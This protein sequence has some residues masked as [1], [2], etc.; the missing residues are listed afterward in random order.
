V[1]DLGGLA[2]HARALKRTLLLTPW[3]AL[4]T[5]SCDIPPTHPLKYIASPRGTYKA[6]LLERPGG[7]I[8]RPSWFLKVLRIREEIDDRLS[9]LAIQ[10][11]YSYW[12]FTDD[13]SANMARIEVQWISDDSLVASI[14]SRAVI[15]AGTR[16]FGGGIRLSR[17]VPDSVRLIVNTRYDPNWRP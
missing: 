7:T 6:V 5:I 17:G 8:T 10:T 4:T 14:D 16:D 1:G 9:P 15:L 12:R 13:D 3:I 2:D 11:P